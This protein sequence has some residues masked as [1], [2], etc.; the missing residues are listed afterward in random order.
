MAFLVDID[1]LNR[2]IIEMQ[3][4]LF[5]ADLLVTRIALDLL[6]A[7]GGKF[8]LNIDIPYFTAA[9]GYRTFVTESV[10]FD[11]EMNRIAISENSGITV[12]WDEIDI[13]SKALIVN[14]ACMKLTSDS[15]YNKLSAKKD[16]H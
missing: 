12:S 9:A 15:I 4:K 1:R 7:C 8:T 16:A 10:F 2:R 3:E 5:D 11:A 13:Q 6:D 14:E